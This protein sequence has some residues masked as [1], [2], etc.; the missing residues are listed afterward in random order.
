[1][2]EQFEKFRE[3][4]FEKFPKIGRLNKEMIIT[5]K[6]D[7]INAQIYFNKF[8]V[9][10]VGSKNRW[11]YPEGWSGRAKGC[12]KFG[13]AQWAYTNSHNL[14]DFL[15]EGRHYGE[16]A[17][18]GIQRNYGLDEKRFYLFNCGRWSDRD[19]PMSLIKAG[20]RVISVLYIGY[21]SMDQ[22]NKTME[23]L[24]V[25]GSFINCFPR[26]EGVIIFHTGTRTT[27]KVTFDFDK[28]KW[29]SQT[30]EESK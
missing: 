10:S 29:S 18:K 11:I 7:G 8:G 26:P 9:M 25:S 16:W 5:E 23:Y 24:Q 12:D 21:Y 20:L 4:P 27:A 17:G 3:E 13:F 6:I 1:M 30:N 22:I 19:I 14:L 28:G 15:G 2:K